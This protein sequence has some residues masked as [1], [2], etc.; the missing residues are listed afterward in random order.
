MS[1]TLPV[2]QGGA[3]PDDE[4]PHLLVVDDDGRIRKLLSRYLSG[5]GYRVTTA[6]DAA[7]ARRR[8]QGLVFDLI[9]LDLMLPGES[10]LSF[11]LSTRQVSDIPILMLTARSE[12]EHRIEGLEAGADDYL[13]K[14]FEPRELLLRI[15]S[16]LRRRSGGEEREDG[17]TVT[18]GPF[19]FHTGRAELKCRGQLVR[20]TERERELL[21]L[22]ASRPRE[23]ISR[24]ELAASANGS[25][26]AVDVQ[27]NRLRRKIELDPANPVHL[28]TV[29]GI[30]YRLQVD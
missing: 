23:T 9:V 30:G 25:E 29:R 22:F 16:V 19:R 20:L 24:L 7:E 3:P 10:G 2:A 8:M 5:N 27:M 15:A 11:A 21:Q 18:F 4:A 14:P 26:R 13:S 6:E 12:T 28:Q 1:G 17:E